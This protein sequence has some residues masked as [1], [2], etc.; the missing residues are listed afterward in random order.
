MQLAVCVH[1]KP[2]AD[3]LS[4]VLAQY[5]QQRGVELSCHYFQTDFSLL[6]D[7]I[8]GEF[9]AVFCSGP[10][11]ADLTKEL[12]KRDGGV[13]LVRLIA[14]D[15]DLDEDGGGLW[16]CLP[17]PVNAL[18]LFP[19]L[20]RLSAELRRRNEAKLL[21]KT[22]GSVLYLPFSQIEYA[23]VSGR[24]VCFHLVGGKSEAVPG[25]FSEYEERLLQWPDFVKVHRAFII[26]LR[27]I[28]KLSSDTILTRSGHAVPV[29]QLLYPKFKRDYLCSLG[30]D[31]LRMPENTPE[32][33]RTAA[34][35]ECY[36]L[37]VDDEHSER[38]RWSEA[39]AR[40]GCTVFSAAS[41][42]QAMELAKLHRFDCVLLDVQLGSDS[43]FDLC[44]S[45]GC[46]TGAPVLYLSVLSD[47]DHQKQG[48]LTGGADYLTK[49][50]PFDLLWLKIQRRMET[51]KA[52]K[53]ELVCG[54]LRL[55]LRLRQAFLREQAVPLTAVEF[56]IL[57]LLVQNPGTPYP[58]ERLYQLIWGT[59]QRDDGHTVQMHMTQLG[60][61]L[62]SRYPQHHFIGGVWGAG[63]RFV[64]EEAI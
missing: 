51:A 62:E 33:N 21:I 54:S 52:A 53:P 43:G 22:K 8:P 38:A 47:A 31:M 58:P 57:Y 25:A 50:T 20:D 5:G 45:L 56:D 11:S 46:Q 9:D 60:N 30:T 18:F 41:G 17:D 19:L 37:L 40:V 28:Q 1:N 44:Q 36:I 34:G 10:G 32:P 3:L 55:D 15:A 7:F 59:R 2:S 12:R 6:C 39:L 63:Y 24:T 27:H 35:D 23:E 48:F 29:S 13:H 61:K 42:P 26:N 4:R 14:A 64:P 49:D 16:Y